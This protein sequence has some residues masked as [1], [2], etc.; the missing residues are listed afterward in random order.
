MIKEPQNYSYQEIKEAINN[1]E[2]KTKR[3]A[4]LGY[5]SGARVSE[6]N[7]IKKGNISIK[8]E[9]MEIV[10]PVLK[11]R[12]GLGSRK[13]LIRL[14]ET[15]LINP[16]KELME[17]KHDLDILLPYSRNYIWRLVR[18]IVVKGEK[19]NPHAFRKLR[20]THLATEFGYDGQKLKHF[21]DWSRSDMADNYVKLNVSDLRY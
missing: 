19:F 7:K 16:I 6:L 17:G 18:K 3:I 9:Y 4:C 5:G 12:D 11:K 20:A 14:D 10:C 15:W 21:F 13:A 8:E 2:T 1:L